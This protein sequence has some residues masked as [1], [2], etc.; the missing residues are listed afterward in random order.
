MADFIGTFVSCA[1]VLAGGFVLA[2]GKWEIFA[3][4]QAGLS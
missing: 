4:K 2:K 1:M 3:A